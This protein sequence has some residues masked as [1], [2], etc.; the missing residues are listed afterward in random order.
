MTAFLLALACGICAGGLV[1][2]EAREA[3]G[4]QRLLKTSASALF[5][6]AALAA[7][8][9]ETSYGRAVVAGL[10]LCAIGDVLLLSKRSAAFLAGIGAF[11]AGHLAYVGAFALAGPA[12]G[13]AAAAGLFAMAAFSGL[14]LRWLWPHLGAFR[15]PVAAYVAII[16]A[17]V[18]AAI[19]AAAATGDLRIAAG[20]VL[21]AIS[22]IAVARD[23]FVREDFAN[24]L[25]GLPLYYSAQL[26]LAST[27]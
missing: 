12:F 3:R 16:S 7:G 27:V 8:G 14:T 19:A 21:F 17:M 25:W 22:D 4:A 13:A 9:L 18:V 6:L 1:L 15:I 24:R 2:A 20:G 5:I 11:A 26:L 23:R 10:F